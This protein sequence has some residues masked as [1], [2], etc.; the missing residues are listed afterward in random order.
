MRFLQCVCVC[1]YELGSDSPGITSREI[2]EKTP[3]I[4]ED[5]RKIVTI[6]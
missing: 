4:L 2:K 1:K 6:T 5:M 3:N